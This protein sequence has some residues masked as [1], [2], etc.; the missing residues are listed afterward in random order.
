MDQTNYAE[1]ELTL[2]QTT[3][4]L[5]RSKLKAFADD[6]INVIEKQKFLLGLVENIVGKGEK[7][8]HQHFLLFQQ[9]FQR[10]SCSGSLKVG[11]V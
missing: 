5:D 1:W 9:C 11:I 4:F 10:V 7:A 2:Y 8:G 6:K 3:N